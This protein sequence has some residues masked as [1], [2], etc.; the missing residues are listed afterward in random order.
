MGRGQDIF[1]QYRKLEVGSVSAE[2]SGS[3]NDL[4]FKIDVRN[5][6][7]QEAATFEAKLWNLKRETWRSIQPNDGFRATVG[8]ENGEQGVVC[9][10][11]VDQKWTEHSEND[12]R[13]CVKGMGV[14]GKLLNLR[15]THTY[16]NQ[17]IHQ[18]ARDIATQVGLSIENIDKVGRPFPNARKR[19]WTITDEQPLTE[20][21]DELVDAAEKKT[22]RRWEWRAVDGKFA[23][24]RL[25]RKRAA[26][27]VLSYDNTLLSLQEATD[28]EDAEEATA[29]ATPRQYRF[30]TLCEPSLR[31]GRLVEVDTEDVRGIF[32][33]TEVEHVSNSTSGVHETKG[34]IKT[35]EGFAR[36]GDPVTDVEVIEEWK[37]IQRQ[38]GA[39]KR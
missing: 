17:K 6:E 12:T 7:E 35:T 20:W 18:I 16:R 33:V 8:W 2:N 14:S 13:F 36:P 23:F 30:T 4:D 19:T 25:D 10:G 22:N 3:S 15:F 26:A 9:L 27:T 5:N 29:G 11:V 24:E 1:Q 21:L 31:L 28:S 38:K 32:R 39:F 37:R 34:V